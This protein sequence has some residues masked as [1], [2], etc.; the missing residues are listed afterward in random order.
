MAVVSVMVGAHSAPNAYLRMFSKSRTIKNRAYLVRIGCQ[1][2][3]G[4]AA[5]RIA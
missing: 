1:A 2:A 3:F 4:A 5:P